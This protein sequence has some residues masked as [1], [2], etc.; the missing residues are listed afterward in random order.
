VTTIPC[1]AKEAFTEGKNWQ[2]LFYF[3][4]FLNY[5]T[6]YITEIVTNCTVRVPSVPLQA[7]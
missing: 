5:K 4:Q 6:I 7:R 1:A 2:Q 3:D